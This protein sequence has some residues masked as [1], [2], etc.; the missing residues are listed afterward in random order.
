VTRCVCEKNRPIGCPTQFV[1]TITYITCTGEKVAQKFELL[2][3]LKN[4][5]KVNNCPMGENSPNLVT[6]PPTPTG[7][8]RTIMR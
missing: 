7:L 1:K 5:A 3:Y 8:K 6:L 2:L 4:L